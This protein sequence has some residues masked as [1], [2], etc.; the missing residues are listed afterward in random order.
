M[1]TANPLLADAITARIGDGW[2]TQLEQ[3]AN[4]T[5]HADDPAFRSEVRAIKQRNKE[6]LARY[7]EAERRI[8]VDRNSIFDV[9]VKRLHEYKRQHLNL[10]HIVAL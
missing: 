9:Q 8:A 4:L 5:E 10:L 3:L 7:I 1:L 2:I 6:Q